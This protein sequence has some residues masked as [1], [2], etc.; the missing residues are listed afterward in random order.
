MAATSKKILDQIIEVGII[1]VVRAETKEQVRGAVRAL[2]E[3][4]IPA[5]EITFTV[6]NAVE[7]IRLMHAE[8]GESILLGAGTVITPADAAAAIAAGAAYIVSPNTSQEIIH[9]CRGEGVPVMPGA[10]T[11]SEIVS[12]W[13]AGA[14]LIKIFPAE[15]LGPAFIKAIRAPL[16]DVR[17][18]PTGGVTAENAAEWLAAGA[19][20]LAAGGSLVDKKALAS[21]RFEIITDKAR[22][23]VQ[24]IQAYRKKGR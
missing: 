17:L 15:I 22:Q 19:T 8:Y 20:A 3:G 24:A 6:P 2:K 9:F 16:P 23:F 4:G 18:M 12:A 14:D 21:G 7:M 11:P 13:S 10:M 5:I 1:A